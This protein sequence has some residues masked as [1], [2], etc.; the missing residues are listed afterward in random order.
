MRISSDTPLN[1]E[2]LS[3]ST[4]IPLDGKLVDFSLAEALFANVA[5][6]DTT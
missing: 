1:R 3:F 2:R 6:V 5:M 4:V